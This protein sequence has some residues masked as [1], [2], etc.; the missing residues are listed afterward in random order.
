[1]RTRDLAVMAALALVLIAAATCRGRD[2]NA[3]PP[4]PVSEAA[5]APAAAGGTQTAQ[6][7]D[8]VC[9]AYCSP[10][11]PGT[12][13]AEIKWDVGIQPSS[14][15]IR[16]TATQQS[17]EVAVNEDGFD[18]GRFARLPSLNPQAR[19]APAAG[20]PAG[21]APLPGLGDLTV[22]GVTSSQEAAGAMRLATP[23]AAGQENVVV[24]VQGLKPGL[25]Y[26]WRVRAATPGQTQVVMC[27]A[28]VCPADRRNR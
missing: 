23:A 15:E 12:P 3:N 25:N 21:T 22:R 5:A 18:R 13:V 14:S 10:E 27:R 9:V 28:P 8:L 26:Y 20:Q 4:P 2:Q 24:Q 6:A 17:V 19:F 1:M 16:R 7:G 11:Q